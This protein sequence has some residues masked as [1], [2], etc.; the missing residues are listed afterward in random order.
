MH[1]K[2]WGSAQIWE[3]DWWDTCQN[4]YFEQQK[5]LIYAEKMGL[6]RSST[7]KTPYN[8]NLQG[9]SILDIGGGPTSLLLKCYNG[10][11]KVIDPLKFPDWVA[12]RYKTAGIEY[13]QK[14]GEELSLDKFYDII[15]IYNVLQ[16]CEN[17]E[18]IIDNARI[19]GKEIRIFEYI[20]T[21]PNIGHPQTLTEKNLNK[22]LE[23]E[24]K[25]EKLD[26]RNGVRGE[27]YYGIFKGNNYNG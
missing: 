4:T 5:Q 6:T 26:G 13:E 12:Q 22:L 18:L 27:V 14:K 15:F 20:N 8:F 23:G 9:K 10:K 7:P 19:V 11:G 21:S 24:G 3:G 25:T 2:D 16:H 17:P 1:N